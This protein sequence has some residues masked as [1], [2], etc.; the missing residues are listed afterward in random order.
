MGTG[1]A[2][3]APDIL[4]AKLG[5]HATRP[6]VAEAL[7]AANT[8][9]MALLGALRGHGLREQDLRTHQIQLRPDHGDDGEITG[10]VARHMVTATLRDLGRADEILEAAVQAAGDAAILDRVAFGIAG[11]AGLRTQARQAAFADAAAKAEQYAAL[12]GRSLGT[13]VRLVEGTGGSAPADSDA[14]YR[15]ASIP[16]T[17][18]VQDVVVHVTVTWSWG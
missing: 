17:P 3:A 8:A 1:M 15:T 14:S 2:S 10:Y 4:T 7:S 11:H 6:A 12:A 5:A 9:A 13:L 16:I 18:G